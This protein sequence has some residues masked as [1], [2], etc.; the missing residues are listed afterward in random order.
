MTP[1]DFF[2]EQSAV[3]NPAEYVELFDAIPDDI[4]S[5][6]RASYNVVNHY[7]GDMRYKPPKDR[8]GEVETRFISK[9]LEYALSM[10]D[11][12]LMQRRKDEHRV[13][14]CC[15][16]FTAL[17]VAI[18][19]HK[20]IPAR[21]RYGTATYFEAGYYWDHV[22]VEYWNGERWVGVDSQLSPDD[23]REFDFDIRDVPRD[24]FL[25]GGKGWQLARGG[26]DPKLFGLGSIQG[27]YEFIVTEILLDL[28]AL[29]RDEHLCWEC[30]GYSDQNYTTFTEDDL[31]FL[32]E[33]A[34]VT[35]DNNA[36]NNGASFSN[37]PS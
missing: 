13:V 25:V 5:I 22:I 18:L 17:T 37:I 36:L 31:T 11:S 4:E 28:A 30:W 9:M 3:T 21:A 24:K 19:R 10:D 20:G 23:P 34:R 1:Q 15:R 7:I 6:C 14:G 32:D 16:D 2:R 26:M 33:V 29:N 27:G 8:W 35:E 12:P